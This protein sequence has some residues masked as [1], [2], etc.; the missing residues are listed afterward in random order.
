[1]LTTVHVFLDDA[2]KAGGEGGVLDIKGLARAI[3]GVGVGMR[4]CAASED[5]Q[6]CAIGADDPF[7]PKLVGMDRVVGQLRHRV[8]R[9]MSLRHSNPNVCPTPSPPSDGRASRRVELAVSVLNA[10]PCAGVLISGPPG[11]GKT[12]V[13]RW[14]VGNMPGS[15]RYI[16]VSC[17]NLVHKV[18]GESERRLAQL[19]ETGECIRAASS[20]CVWLTRVIIAWFDFTDSNLSCSS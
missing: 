13:S 5:A 14:L 12:A 9:P 8:I 4:A 17:S 2:S 16:E 19:F 10:K 11:A 3:D 15:F 20:A 18:V 7:I 6:V 1:M